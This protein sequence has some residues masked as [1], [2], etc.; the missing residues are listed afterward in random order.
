MQMSLI[1]RLQEGTQGGRNMYLSLYIY[2][3]FFFNKEKERGNFNSNKPGL[4]R[5]AGLILCSQLASSHMCAA[6]SERRVK[7]LRTGWIRS[8][9]TQPG[10]ARWGSERRGAE[11]RGAEGVPGGGQRQ[12]GRSGPGRHRAARRREASHSWG[13]PRLRVGKLLSC[14]SEMN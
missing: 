2:K 4:D 11:E 6:C 8:G 3:D 7:L 1:Y 12:V 13:F 10:P 9:A 5:R 14:V